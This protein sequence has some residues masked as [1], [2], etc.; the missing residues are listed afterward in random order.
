MK[1]TL[2]T[3]SIMLAM[4]MILAACRSG[5]TTTANER[6]ADHTETSA[7]TTSTVD[8]E[9]IHDSI[10]IYVAGDTVQV[11][12]WRTCWRDRLV[13]DTVYDHRTDTIHDTRYEEKVVEVPAKG[14]ATGWW[15][16]AALFLLIVV[17][18]LFKSI[19]KTH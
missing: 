13:H 15:V 6:F 10:Y 14:A 1:P 19:F 12:R 5:R 9:Y 17:N 16:A 4:A 18:L 3:L 11:V 7:K 2:K 8:K